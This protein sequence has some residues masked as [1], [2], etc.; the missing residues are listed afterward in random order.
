MTIITLIVFY[1]KNVILAC[2]TRTT[3]KRL[4]LSF[5]MG[6]FTFFTANTQFTTTNATSCV[7]EI[8]TN[9]CYLFP[10]ITAL[11][12]GISNNGLIW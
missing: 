11:W 9:N 4:L 3:I 8:A 12:K 6:F 1:I 7:C 5:T 10:D 2:Q